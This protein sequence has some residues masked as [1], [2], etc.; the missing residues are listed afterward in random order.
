[1]PKKYF[2]PPKDL[3]KEWPEVFEG[4]YMNTMPVNYVDK[5]ILEFSDG[6]VWE[7]DIASKKARATPESIATSLQKILKEN[8]TTIKKIDFKINIE[9]LRK[10]I[11]GRT[12]D[13]L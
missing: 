5:I 2:K 3:V 13:I 11:E 12:R 7:I 8:K 4:L 9:Q 10:D 6:R 1:M